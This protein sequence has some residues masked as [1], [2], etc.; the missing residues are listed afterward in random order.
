MVTSDLSQP[1]NSRRIR[2]WRQV[3]SA[4]GDGEGATA[5]LRTRCAE[6]HLPGGRGP[7]HRLLLDNRRW[8]VARLRTAECAARSGV[9]FKVIK[10]DP[11][12][13]SHSFLRCSWTR[14]STALHSKIQEMK[15][16]RKGIYGCFHAAFAMACKEPLGKVTVAVARDNSRVPTNGAVETVCPGPF[17]GES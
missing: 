14:T 2:P 13:G 11:R 17:S 8:L 4:S 1:M 12:F 5:E 9:P 6:A 15:L 3:H 10:N 16:S 7:I